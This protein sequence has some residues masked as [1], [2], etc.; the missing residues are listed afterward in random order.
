[1]DI[2]YPEPD[3]RRRILVVEPNRTNLGVIA[4]RLAE[5]GYRVTTADSGATAIAELYR[6]P[7]DL[8]LAELNMPRM[9]GA[10]LARAIRGEVQWNELPIML[11]TGK[12]DPKGA[13]NAYESGADDVILKPFHFEVLLARIERR[14]QRAR[15][16]R[17]LQEDNAA[18]DARVVE[19]AIQIGELKDALANARR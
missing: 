10:E 16:V 3:E 7:I 5:A 4:R 6:L 1:M 14:I 11:I 18:L 15:A 8:V 13:V 9:S 19:R 2:R 17:R 12:S